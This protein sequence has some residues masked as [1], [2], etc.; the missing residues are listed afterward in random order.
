MK[1]SSSSA[2]SYQSLEKTLGF[3]RALPVTRDWSAAADFLK[4][5]SEYCL[6]NKPETIVECS[7]GTS[8]LVLSQCCQLNQYGHVYSLENGET[9]VE[10][11]QQQLEDFVLTDCCD[12]IHAPLQDVQLEDKEFQWYG[13]EDLS[14][15]RID[16]LVIDGPPG[17]I[18][19]HSRYAALPLL[20]DRLSDRCVIFL[21]DAARE[22]EQETVRSGFNSFHHVFCRTPP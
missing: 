13:L 21:D 11:T 9:F 6:E 7:S 12:V 8:S 20:Y 15:A 5:V 4:V 2:V 18:Q 14:T 22:D 17:F 1:K 10:K 16:L 19:R 3:D